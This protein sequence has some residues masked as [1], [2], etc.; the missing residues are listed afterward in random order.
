MAADEK[1]EQVEKINK[2][3][4]NDFLQYMSYLIDKNEM[5][6]Q[7]DKFQDNLRKAKKNR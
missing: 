7:E 5:Q 6:E 2:T 4:L 3:Y 1:I